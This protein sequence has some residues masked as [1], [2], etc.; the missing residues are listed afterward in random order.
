MGVNVA[1]THGRPA[2]AYDGLWLGAPHPMLRQHTA[3]QGP[4]L[5]TSSL[6]NNVQ[7][8]KGTAGRTVRLKESPQH[9]QPRMLPLLNE[10]LASRETRYQELRVGMQQRS[11]NPYGEKTLATAS[12]LRPK[13][14]PYNHANPLVPPRAPTATGAVG[15]GFFISSGQQ[16]MA[17][18]T[19]A[20][21]AAQQYVVRLPNT[22]SQP[23]AGFS[24]NFELVGTTSRASMRSRAT[25]YLPPAD[26]T[27]R[28]ANGVTVPFAARPHSQAHATASRAGGGGSFK[29]SV[30]VGLTTTSSSGEMTTAAAKTRFTVDAVSLLPPAEKPSRAEPARRSVPVTTQGRRAKAFAALEQQHPSSNGLAPRPLGGVPGTRRPAQ[31]ALV[32]A[33]QS[34]PMLYV[35][36]P[37][38]PIASRSTRFNAPGQP[39][40]G[41][42]YLAGTVKGTR[43]G[44][45]LASD[46][47]GDL[48]IGM[49][50]QPTRERGTRT[51]GRLPEGF[52]NTGK[53]AVTT[54]PYG[55]APAPE[56]NRPAAPT[57]V[58]NA[59]FAAAR[60]QDA[61]TKANA[62]RFD[63][64]ARG[65][66]EAA[67]EAI[68]PSAP[69][70]DP[71]LASAQAALKAL[72]RR[73]AARERLMR[74]MDFSG[75]P[76]GLVNALAE[77]LDAAMS[78][79]VV[80]TESLMSEALR[81]LKRAEEDA[82][83]DAR[84]AGNAAAKAEAAMR[85]EEAAL[86][87]P[88]P[89][90][91]GAR[92]LRDGRFVVQT[93]VGEGAY[94]VVMRCT[95]RGEKP[96][97]AHKTVAVKEFKVEDSDPDAEDV[98]RTARREVSLLK[99]MQHPHI[100]R[101]IQEFD[102]REKLFIVME[103]VP[104]N[105]L[106][107]LE[108]AQSRNGRGGLPKPVVKRIM[109]QLCLALAYIHE[110]DIVYRDVKPENLLVAERVPNASDNVNPAALLD[111][112]DG[113]GVVLE[114]KLCDFGFARPLGP[115]TSAADKSPTW[116]DT[117]DILTDYVA[118]RW[119]RA[120]ELLLG[121][122]FPG[123]RDPSALVHSPY[124]VGVDMWAVGCLMGECLDG[125]PLFPGDSDIDQLRRVQE[126]LGRLTTKQLELFLRNPSNTNA[127][128]PFDGP[129]IGL[130]ARYGHLLNDVELSF[131]AD[132]LRVD[133]KQRMSGEECLA[134][135]IFS[136]A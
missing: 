10:Q 36:A 108:D 124:G 13:T 97:A 128:F 79:G 107:V 50:P 22:R 112:G 110:C 132:L 129:P 4:A 71:L 98:R 48:Y 113:V 6:M 9:M 47:N 74:A 58:L 51:L 24:V 115:N 37:P 64:E 99:R 95:D 45:Q 83:A 7:G 136:D 134:H 104:K 28:Q 2:Q 15:G 38:P 88:M 86:V 103:F 68:A 12:A 118:T 34:E 41:N 53:K 70:G 49:V 80:E 32:T 92:T 81:E 30:V 33:E 66:L 8:T 69:K 123:E 102:E 96:T 106:E 31:Q 5:R 131:M 111:R 19:A 26:A 65:E 1:P 82:R 94:G 16:A 67:I 3:Q 117:D 91:A 78:A 11:S 76:A 55:A 52:G 27:T 126:M 17:P 29:G 109:Y 77:A 14:T 135:A 125:E 120:P 130:D 54:L 114:M 93:V 105:L 35:G 73:E 62:K 60:V 25:P 44:A 56:V 20:A 84:R 75:P 43:S 87:H 90:E 101:F 61:I 42:Q 72:W 100:V 121:P 133:P 40:I 39:I 46:R 63:A 23:P 57:F 18:Q 85:E 116:P 119:Y 89:T 59:G 127:S 122:P 21:S